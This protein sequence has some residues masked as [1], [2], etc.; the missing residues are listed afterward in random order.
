MAE[1]LSNEDAVHFRTRAST[2]GQL[3]SVRGFRSKKILLAVKRL[4]AMGKGSVIAIANPSGLVFCGDHV[5]G[6]A[7]VFTEEGK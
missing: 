5:I 6:L 3:V 4:P 2:G 7:V 1:R